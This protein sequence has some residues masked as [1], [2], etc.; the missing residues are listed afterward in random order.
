MKSILRR[1]M[2]IPKVWLH[3]LFASAQDPRQVFVAAYQHQRELL[4]KVRLAQANIAVSKRRLQAKTAETERKLPQLDE[5]ARQALLAGREESARFALQLRQV[6]VEE[7]HNLERQVRDIEDEEQVLSLVEQRLAAQIEAFF[8]RQEVLAAR[9]ST[10]EAQVQINE[11]LSGVSDELAG[12]GQAME[13]AEQRTEDMQARVSAIDQLVEMGIL[14]APG[15]P[16]GD[17]LQLKQ[18]DDESSQAVEEKLAAL[19]R[20]LGDGS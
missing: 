1:L 3:A 18:G 10:A 5:Q 16:L 9:Y 19:K 7:L 20:E 13:R 4:E 12:L 6:A 17:L 2:L 15:R 8:A 14:E 11:A